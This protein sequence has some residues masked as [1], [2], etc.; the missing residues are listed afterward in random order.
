MSLMTSCE[1]PHHLKLV[2]I[3]LLSKTNLP[4][5]QTYIIDTC[6]LELT[7]CLLGISCII[8]LYI[9]FHLSVKVNTEWD[10]LL[11]CTF[12]TKQNPLKCKQ[13]VFYS[14]LQ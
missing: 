6:I 14:I 4:A 5:L 1:A 11:N 13:V 3:V 9:T 8:Y 2:A 10:H 7:L 12:Q